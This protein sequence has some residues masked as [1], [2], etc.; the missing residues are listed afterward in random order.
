MDAFDGTDHRK[1]LSE[2]LEVVKVSEK[3]LAYGVPLGV[4]AQLSIYKPQKP[5][6][7][8]QRGGVAMP[9]KALRYLGLEKGGRVLVCASNG[10]LYLFNDERGRRLTYPGGSSLPRANFMAQRQ[11]RVSSLDRPMFGT[12]DKFGRRGLFIEATDQM[13]EAVRLSS[14]RAKKRAADVEV[15][16]DPLAVVKER[17]A[18]LNEAM[19][20]VDGFS[21]ETV[22][23]D[24][25]KIKMRVAQT[26][27]L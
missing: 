7:P 14:E 4:N 17:L 3:D 12:G 11:A 8:R 1:T 16:S 13:I 25:G 15:V 5:G 2:Q 6:S 9:E 26:M 20:E 23:L 10:V 24:G 27:D 22:L 19:S 21:I 18:A